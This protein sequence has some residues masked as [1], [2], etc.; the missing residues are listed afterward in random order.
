MFKYFS[1]IK[2]NNKLKVVG[3]KMSVTNL[4]TIFGPNLLHNH[5]NVANNNSVADMTIRK[6]CKIYFNLNSVG[7]KTIFVIL[8]NQSKVFGLNYLLEKFK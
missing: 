2:N 7:K 3:N 5:K 6:V 8:L 4:A 1:E